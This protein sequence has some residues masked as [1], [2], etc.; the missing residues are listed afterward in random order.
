[1]Y[2]FEMNPLYK[3]ATLQEIFGASIYCSHFLACGFNY[4]QGWVF[5]ATFAASTVGFTVHLVIYDKPLLERIARPRSILSAAAWGS[6]ATALMMHARS[7]TE[8]P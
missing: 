3:Q 5:L 7:S 1:V 8:T 6:L 4:W 2:R